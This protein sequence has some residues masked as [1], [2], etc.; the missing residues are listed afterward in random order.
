MK[1]ISSI[2]LLA[3]GTAFGVAMVLSCGDDAR[4]SDAATCDCPNSEPP[5]AGRIV[6][7]DSDVVTL[8]PGLQGAA[9]IGCNPGM[10]FISGSCGPADLSTLEDIVIQAAAFDNADPGGWSCN[11]KNNKSTPVRV[12]ASIRCLK[13]GN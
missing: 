7:I 8:A 1:F 5:L 4:R 11:F 6:A 10:I 2:I 3:T 9:G 13:P 12:K